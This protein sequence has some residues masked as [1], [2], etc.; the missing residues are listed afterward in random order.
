M[1]I[2]T[3][4]IICNR[5]FFI[6]DQ[7]RIRK[8]PSLVMTPS[9]TLKRRNKSLSESKCIMKYWLFLKASDT[10]KIHLLVQK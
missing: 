5:L 3:Q 4:E 10:A 2:K 7:Q 6:L 9:V 1:E 8:H